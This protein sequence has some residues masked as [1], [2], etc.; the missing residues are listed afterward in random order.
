[1]IIKRE[2]LNSEI[3][4]MINE[5]QSNENLQNRYKKLYAIM[6]KLPSGNKID[7]KKVIE[8]NLK[9]LIHKIQKGISENKI[10]NEENLPSYIGKEWSSYQRI[11]F[12]SNVN[13][14]NQTFTINLKDLWGF[15]EKIINIDKNKNYS[16]ESFL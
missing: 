8:S 7:Y 11:L 12:V 13:I 6:E 15:G 1:M 14:T 9:D 10:L 3:D 4:W 5:C 16:N 2:C